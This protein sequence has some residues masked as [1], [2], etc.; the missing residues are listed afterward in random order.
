MNTSSNSLSPPGAKTRPFI[1]VVIPSMN[2]DSSELESRFTEQ[3]W[4]PDDIQVIN[5]ISPSGRARNLGV[6]A[7][8]ERSQGR[9]DQ[10]LVFIDDDAVPGN[11]R[12]IE[13]LVKPLINGHDRK[14]NP[15]GITGA[16]RVLPP[17]ATG[18]QRRVA[19]EI[20]RTTN[21]VP[22]QPLETNPPLQGY[23]HSFITTTCCATWYSIF[24]SAG[25]FSEELPSGEDTDFFY[26]VRKCGYRFIMVPE[27][28]VEHP[29]P[30]NLG[31]LLRKYYWYGV[32]YGLEA[33]LRPDQHIGP[34][35]FTLFHQIAFLIGATLWLIPNIFILYSYGYPHFE[36]G[37][38]PV[39]ALST[40]AVAHGYVAGW[41]KRSR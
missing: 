11:P 12:L 38:R 33:Q 17:Q 1:S 5:G 16:A 35:L 23:G 13:A 29:A 27:V 36:L 9:N 30:E 3:S 40:Y 28:Y 22:A 15:V 26:R 25:K 41:R 14:S 8:R 10:I 4:Q 37:F 6:K 7:A 31:A 18:F 20:P 24:E 21:P 34:R 2:G 32:G 39:K 19:A